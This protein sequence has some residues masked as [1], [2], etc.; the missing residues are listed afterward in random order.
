[1]ADAVGNKYGCNRCMYTWIGNYGCC[2]IC[3]GT[4]THVL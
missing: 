3:C 2:P 4:A 1:M